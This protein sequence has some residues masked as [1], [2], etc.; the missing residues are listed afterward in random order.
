MIKNFKLNLEQ[1]IIAEIKLKNRQENFIKNY[2]I[3]CLIKFIRFTP[4]IALTIEPFTS[5]TYIDR[6]VRRTNNNESASTLKVS[7]P[8]NFGKAIF[9]SF[10][11]FTKKS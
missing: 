1:N 2:Y 9:N 7:L 8:N 6:T 3:T 11:N 10:T 5:D 4:T